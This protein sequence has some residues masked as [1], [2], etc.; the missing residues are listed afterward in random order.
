MQF[1]K[2]AKLSILAVSSTANSQWM[3]VEVI[4]DF[5]MPTTV[6]KLQLLQEVR[7]GNSSYAGSQHAYFT[8]SVR[9]DKQGWRHYCFQMQSCLTQSVHDDALHSITYSSL[10][11]CFLLIPM[12]L[13]R[14]PRRGEREDSLIATP[15]HFKTPF[16]FLSIKIY[17]IEHAVYLFL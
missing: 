5:P 12:E 13:K 10:L 6:K 3:N 15:A 16:F 17:L 7:P 8:D 11:L 2:P 9:N 1:S 4:T 14:M